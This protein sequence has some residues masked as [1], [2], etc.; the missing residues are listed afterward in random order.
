MFADAG[1]ADKAI[2]GLA[3]LLVIV[4]VAAKIYL[5]Y[6]A[7][8][9]TDVWIKIQK[10]EEEMKQQRAERLKKLGAGGVKAAGIIAKLFGK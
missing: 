5:A 4:G 3:I 2:F 6:M 1:F 10:H 9:R 7:M 8:F